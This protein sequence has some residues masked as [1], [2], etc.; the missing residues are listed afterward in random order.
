MSKSILSLLPLLLALSVCA[1]EKFYEEPIGWRGKSIELHTISDREK[2]NSCL[3]LCNGDS[4]RAFVLDSKQAV[5]QHFYF[6]RLQSEQFLGGFMKGGK[7]YAFLQPTGPNTNP[8]LHVWVLDIVKGTHSDFVVLFDMR[9]ESAVEE[10]SCGDRF[11]YFAVNKKESQFTIYDFGEDQRIDTLHYSFENGVW[12]ALTEYD[13][14]FG[15]DVTVVKIDPGLQLNRDLGHV[16]NKLYWMHDTLFLLMNSWQKGVTAIFSFDVQTKKVGLRKVIH[17][18]IQ[19]T[20]PGRANYTDNSFLLDDKLFFVS[21]DDQK[22][23]LQVRDFHSGSLLR[24]YTARSF[25]DSLFINT[26]ID[27]DGP[28]SGKKSREQPKLWQLL[29]M[30]YEGSSVLIV[31]REDSGRIGLTIGAWKEETT[32]R[33]SGG[34]G[35]A[36]LYS[37]S[38]SIES[39]GFKLLMDSTTLE[40][41]PGPVTRGIGD[42]IVD[43]RKKISIPPAGE[44]LFENGGKY[45]Y[46]YYD[47]DEHK[48]VLTNF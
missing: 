19:E 33:R 24:E 7:V 41:V 26:P 45:V 13:G 47:R 23:D 35:S 27:L 44:S 42:R 10:I 8:I 36:P 25:G 43:Y 31:S 9:H 29:K 1:Q 28:L 16:P 18:D 38:T 34:P 21:A 4:V 5:I 32:L 40:H 2:L 14:N 6:N 20:Q 17:N 11:L 48:I 12:K 37:R 46:A 15:R 3:F 39:S 22:M 30:M